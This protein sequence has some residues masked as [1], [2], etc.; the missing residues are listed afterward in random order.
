MI[1]GVYRPSRG[2]PKCITQAVVTRKEDCLRNKGTVNAA[3][4][5]GDSK[6][7]DLLA[8]YFL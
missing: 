6:C 8:F 4:L 5:V 2:I 7:K 1:H 3:V